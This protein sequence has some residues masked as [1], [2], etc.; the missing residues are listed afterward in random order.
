M[1]KKFVLLL[2]L[3]VATLSTAFAGTVDVNTADQATL[4]SL[5]GIGPVKSKA[6][7]DERTKNGP[8]KDANDLA[9][10]V[11]GLGAKSVT[12]LETEGLTVGGSST[13]PTA[14]AGKHEK[15]A[16]AT[17]A[18]AA[19]PPAKATAP[20]KTAAATPSAT[21]ATA[22]ATAAP[23]SNAKPAKSHKK[24]KKDKTKAAASAAS[25]A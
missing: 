4:Q 18:N 23:A 20:A 11:K 12:K 7:I 16:P 10:R 1:L 22:A 2:A 3:L 25:G 17:S 13:P 19:Q 8:F 14:A 21:T 9:Q 6:I 15:A 24:N 5:K